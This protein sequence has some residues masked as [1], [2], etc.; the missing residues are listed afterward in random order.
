MIVIMGVSGSGKTTIG[1]QLSDALGIPFFDAD[2]FHSEE[3]V[4]KM[5]HNIAL[6]DRDRRP[7][8]ESLA[9][10]ISEWDSKNGAVLACS[11]LKESYRKTLATRVNSITWIYLSGSFEVINSRINN[12]SGH[13]MKSTLLQSQFD[14]LEIPDYGIHIDAGLDPKEIVA[15]ITS[16]LEGHG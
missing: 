16:K 6:N 11:A 7:W 1:L 12:R 5:K 4:S 10:K 13:Y 3:N 14:T 2:D 15:T 9:I 8:L